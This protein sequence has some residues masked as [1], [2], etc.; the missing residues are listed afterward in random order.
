MANKK[1]KKKIKIK[2]PELPNNNSEVRAL[3]LLSLSL[4][5]LLSLLGFAFDSPHNNLLG[6]MGQ[7]IGWFF[8]SIFGLGSYLLCFYMA[9][10]SFRLIFQK[11]KLFPFRTTLYFLL[12]LSSFCLILCIGE[13]SFPTAATFLQSHFYP[14]LWERKLRY[15]LGGALFQYLYL[16]L[17][18]FNLYRIFSS[19]GTSI[20][21][22][23][24]FVGSLLLL[25]NLTPAELL[26]KFCRLFPPAS[27]AKSP[28]APVPAESALSKNPARSFLRYVKLRIP[29]SVQQP[30]G[31]SASQSQQ[32]EFL[33]IQP[34]ANLTS[35]P[36][37]SSKQ[38]TAIEKTKDLY[39]EPLNKSK[40]PDLLPLDS[41]FTKSITKSPEQKR[42]EALDAQRVHNGDF[43]SFNIPSFNLLSTPKKIDHSSLKNDLKRQAEVLEETLLSFGIEAKVGQINCGPTINSFEI[44]P[45]I[46]V[47]VQKIKALENDIALNMEAKS[48]RI[49]APIPGKAAVGIEVPNPQPQEVGFRDLLQAYQQSGRK[50][51]IP[52]LL[53]K[54]VNGDYVMNDLTKMPHCIIAGATGSGKSVCINTIV[55]SILLTAKPDEIKMIMVDPKKVELTPYTRLPHM[56][57][58]V[59]TEPQGASAALHWLVKEMERRY[60]LLKITGNRNIETFNNR[61]IDKAFEETLGEEIP[62]RLP[63][64][65][66]IVDE[67]ADLMMVSSSDIETPIAR[68]AQMARAVGIHLILATQRPSREVITGLI[69][70]NF[71]TRISF[72]V[73]SRINSQIILDEVGAESLL[74]NGDMLFLPPASSHLIRAQ[75]AFI[76]DEDINAVIKHICDQAPP[77]YKIASFDRLGKTGKLD[78]DG[79]HDAEFSSADSL[80]E[81]ALDIVQ[82]T[83]NASTTFLQR[84]LKIG[85]A[86]AA[87]LMDELEKNG[88]VGMPDGSK[89]RK[90]LLMGASAKLP[91]EESDSSEINDHEL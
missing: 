13:E 14:G 86:R 25:T 28:S 19:I 44:H 68:I 39:R 75:G 52:V 27:A 37:L 89:A 38:A 74:G 9:W 79:S 50:F 90:V 65:V 58:P 71:P 26:E 47:K 64:I 5:T 60:E 88:V 6:I 15:H 81:Q 87:S 70:A 61:K 49:I 83:G 34:E 69:K 16:D 18:N 41:A 23:S 32:H 85:Y 29:Q 63:Y 82:S 20:I 3:S 72:K 54:A 2:E 57:A 84:K 24:A 36:S 21:A 10:I 43:T 7:H 55:M 53:G 51:H 80:Y 78:D 22:G 59:I 4:I 67:L 30:T 91:K 8:H 33:A 56:L 11:E 62:E 66:C 35:R 76:R 42:Q 45:S 77:N 31:N 46:G 1:S 40:K 12:L 48:I 17:P 73:A